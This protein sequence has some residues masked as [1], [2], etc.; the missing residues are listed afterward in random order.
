MSFL[1]FT[2]FL[3]TFLILSLQTVFGTRNLLSPFCSTT[4]NFT[5]NG[6]YQTNLKELMDYFT[7]ETHYPT[8]FP[9]G[10][11]GQDLDTVHGLVLCTLQASAEDCAKCISDARNY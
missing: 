8:G 4:E 6:T 1:R 10:S 9:L 2:Y 5:A 11:K 3:I 7:Y